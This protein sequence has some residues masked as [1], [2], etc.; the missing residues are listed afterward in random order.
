[1]KCVAITGERRSELVEAP[2]PQARGEFVVV[3]VHAA[4]MC[5][6]YRAF[7]AGQMHQPFGHEAAGEVVEV[8]QPGKVKVGDRVVVMP[9]LPC[10]RCALCLQ[11]DY[12]HCEH[13]LDLERETDYA[14]GNPTYA[15]YLLKQ[16]WLLVPIP[17]GMSYD[18]ASMACC[19]L[20]PTFGAM[21][22]M[23]V[24][25]FDTLLVAGLGPVGLGAVVN[26]V[27]RGARVI[28]VE[29]NPYRAALA[30]RL[31]AEE[32][33]DPS[34]ADLGEQVKDRTGGLGATKAVECSGVGASVVSCVRAVR[35]KGQVAVVGGSG[36]F[37]LHGW[38]DVISK[39][40]TLRGAWHYN[41]ADTPHLMQV[42]ADRGPLL[43]LMITH[44]FPLAEAQQAFELQVSGQCGKVILHPWEER[45]GGSG[46]GR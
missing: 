21:Q 20:G 3:K 45:H 44:T 23:Q 22:L 31:G 36:E 27:H 37:T 9:Q 32:V 38:Q 18:H 5:T 43:D 8:A 33:L 34:G 17:D 29:S 39:G 1:M 25:S 30:K 16:D 41:L 24:G 10:G 15:E 6:E 46:G 4:P 19:G 42:I 2:D 11:G 14:H 35:R 28:G 7:A 12:I 40:L 26:A 13:T